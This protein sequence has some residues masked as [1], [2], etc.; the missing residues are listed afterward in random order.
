MSDKYKLA[1]PLITS[2]WINTDQPLSFEDFRGRVTL[3]TIFQFLCPS[4]MS[5][6][7]PQAKRVRELFAEADVAVIGLHTVFKQHDQ[8]TP[9]DVKRMMREHDIRFPV[10]IDKQ[11]AGERLGETFQSYELRGTPTQ[12]LLDRDGNL[13]KNKFGFDSDLQV[14]AEIMSLLRDRETGLKYTQTGD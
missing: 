11:D 14:G 9:A 4:C 6:A 13:R 8:Q 12:I 5:H 7:V 3:L 1:K 10:A 2:E